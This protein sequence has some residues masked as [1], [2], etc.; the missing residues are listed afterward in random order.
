MNGQCI[1]LFNRTRLNIATYSGT[2]EWETVMKNIPVSQFTKATLVVR[3]H[4]ITTPIASGGSVE[5]GLFEVAP[6]EED[7]GLEFWSSDASGNPNPA[8]SVTLDNS[9]CA[10]ATKAPQLQ[11][12]VADIGAQFVTVARKVTS[13]TSAGELAISADLIL[14]TP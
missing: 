3:V 10:A 6:T 14:K 2:S 4:S 1:R 8:A 5:Y 13:A 7:P 9:N 11:I 12:A